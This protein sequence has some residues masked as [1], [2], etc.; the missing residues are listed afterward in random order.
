[1]P[2]KVPNLK[3]QTRLISFNRT[4]TFP[5]KSRFKLGQ[6]TWDIIAFGPIGG[7]GSNCLSVLS[8]MRSQGKSCE[9]EVTSLDS[10]TV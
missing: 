7:L 8:H 2:T 1:M 5:V 4:I 10:K 9:I 3:S 6:L